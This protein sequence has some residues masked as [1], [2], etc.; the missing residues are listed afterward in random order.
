MI[1]G[2]INK[3]QRCVQKGLFLKKEFGLYQV[4]ARLTKA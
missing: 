3:F 1:A 4:C 2:D